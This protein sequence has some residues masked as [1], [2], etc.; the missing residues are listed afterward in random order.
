MRCP[1]PVSY[2]HLDVYKRQEELAAEF[3]EA[4]VQP[5]DNNDNTGE[6]N[7][8]A[9]LIG[10]FNPAWDAQGGSDA[11]FFQAVSV[12]GMILENKFELYRGN[13]RADRQIEEVL[14]A[15][16][17]AVTSGETAERDAA[18][19]ILPYFIPCQKRLSETGIASVSYTHLIVGVIDL[20]EYYDT[21]DF[22]NNVFIIYNKYDET[23][24]T[25]DKGNKLYEEKMCI[26]DRANIEQIIE[27]TNDKYQ[28]LNQKDYD[29]YKGLF[30]SLM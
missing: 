28:L 22:L 29:N 9:T 27:I 1:A 11:A 10:N 16:E 12:A 17:R 24:I 13:E 4:F 7:E 8:L 21:Y 2:T 6:K 3:D 14:A 5:L 20:L 23:L 26:R 30:I 15:H 25:Y 18:I 19:L